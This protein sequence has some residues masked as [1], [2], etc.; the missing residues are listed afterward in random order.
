MLQ[1]RNIH[2]YPKLNLGLDSFHDSFTQDF[3][4]YLTKIHVKFVPTTATTH[5][6]F[7][8]IVEYLNRNF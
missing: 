5:C 8:I 2:L 6:V 7:F 4:T 1:L 3:V